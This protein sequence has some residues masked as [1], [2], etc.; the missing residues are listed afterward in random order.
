M[1]SSAVGTIGLDSKVPDISMTHAAA[2]TTDI[3][4]IIAHINSNA[5]LVTSISY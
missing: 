4:F 2:A 1:P 5:C 3:V